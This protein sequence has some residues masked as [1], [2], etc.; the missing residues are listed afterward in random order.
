MKYIILIQFIPGNS[1]IW[2]PQLSPEDPIYEFDNH[3]D[4]T[5]KLKELQEKDKSLRKYKVKEK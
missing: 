2:V 4:A 5:I 3:H 1:T